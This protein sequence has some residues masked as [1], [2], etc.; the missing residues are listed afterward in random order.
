MIEELRHLE[1]PHRRRA[2]EA[3]GEQSAERR[4]DHIF[5]N[6]LGDDLE[7]SD[8]GRSPYFGNGWWII[9]GLLLALM[10]LGLVA[11]AG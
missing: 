2:S 1:T 8:Y 5:F 10:L 6:T 3:E 7:F 4:S 9:P 11:L